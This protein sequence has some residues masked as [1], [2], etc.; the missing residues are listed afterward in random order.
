MVFQY[1]KVLADQTITM[2]QFCK[3]VLCFNNDNVSMKNSAA[4]W[5]G[6]TIYYRGC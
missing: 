6:L 2:L 1:K 5:V 4:I 3:A